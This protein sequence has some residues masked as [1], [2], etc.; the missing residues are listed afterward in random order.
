MK[1]PRL[2]PVAVALMLAT[3]LLLAGT[4]TA[5]A[6]EPPSCTGKT[7]AT[8]GHQDDTLLFMSPRLQ[9]ELDSG[10][11]VRTVFVTAG[12]AG[13]PASYWEGREAG[14]EAAYAEMAGV[15]DT[16]TTGSVAVA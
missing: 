12:D 1:W 8:A 3:G 11:C 16:W 10:R 6:A 4:A 9:S 15:A 14:V 5:A 7:L 2:R 13:M